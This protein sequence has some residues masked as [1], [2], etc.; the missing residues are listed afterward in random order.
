MKILILEPNLDQAGTLARYFKKNH[1]GTHITGGFIGQKPRFWRS[2]FF[3]EL[4]ELDAVISKKLGEYEL[5]IPT[6]SRSTRQLLEQQAGVKLGDA[7]LDS[8]VLYVYD[9]IKMVE[10]A[11]QLKI[12]VPKTY[13]SREEI[14]TFPVFYKPSV[15]GGAAPR[16]VARC[17]AELPTMAHSDCLIYQEYIDTPGTYA[18]GFLANKGEVVTRTIQLE[19]LSY[20]ETGGSGVVVEEIECEQLS[21]HADQLLRAIAYSGWGLIEFKYC[22]VRD[23]FVFMEVNAKFWASLELMLRN[24]HEFTTRLFGENWNTAT[25]QCMV[26]L[27]R[28]LRLGICRFVLELVRH[29]RC[30]WVNRERILRTVLTNFSKRIRNL[31]NP[32]FKIKHITK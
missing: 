21:R 6:G 24:N 3:D 26:F 11:S 1:H 27:N 23:D 16:G 31:R 2:R 9:K 14:V 4:L 17:A 32:I 25:N 20:P 13:R 18:M 12:P 29:R 8:K 19:H 15:E 5:V 30:T 10:L 22:S 28:L 7:Y